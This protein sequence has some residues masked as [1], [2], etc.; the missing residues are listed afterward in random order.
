MTRGNKLLIFIWV[1]SMDLFLIC[2]FW[3]SYYNMPYHRQ[4]F[5]TTQVINVFFIEPSKYHIFAARGEPVQLKTVLR[6]NANSE[7]QLLM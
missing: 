7:A 3:T 6:N 5:A 1:P 2:S 4:N